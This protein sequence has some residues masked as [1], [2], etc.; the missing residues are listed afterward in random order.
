[1]GAL[2]WA[3]NAA[4]PATPDKSSSSLSKHTAQGKYSL[5]LKAAQSASYATWAAMAAK[6]V[7]GRVMV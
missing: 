2:G 5:D 7:A 1:M 6:S 3:I 4:A